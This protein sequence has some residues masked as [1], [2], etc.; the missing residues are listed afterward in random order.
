MQ[1]VLL[2]L[3]FFIR[4]NSEELRIA[5]MEKHKNDIDVINYKI[6]QEKEK[7][8]KEQKINNRKQANLENLNIFKNQVKIIYSL[9]STFFYLYKT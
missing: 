8:I 2:F 6:I 3:F 1:V 4:E 9:E 5:A 7:F